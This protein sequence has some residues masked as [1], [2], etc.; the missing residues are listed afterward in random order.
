MPG[1]RILL[2]EDDGLIALDME[3]LLAEAGYSVAG[4]AHR[5]SSALDLIDS[6]ALDAAVLDVSLAGE[7]VWPVADALAARNTPFVLL[8]GFGKS[9]AIPQAHVGA[10]LLPKPVDRA[11]LVACLQKLLAPRAP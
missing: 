7:T 6:L 8:T 11:A 10:P 1:R 9:L 4:V 2:V 3:D 5:V